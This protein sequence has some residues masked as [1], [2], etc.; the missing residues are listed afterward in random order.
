VSFQ[1]LVTAWAAEAGTTG[2]ALYDRQRTADLL[3]TFLGHDDAARVTAE[4]VVRW[5]EARLAAGRSTKT[6]ANDIGELRP[7]W[8]W[9]KLNRKL[10]FTENPFAGLAPKTRK[11]GR[12][13]RGPYTEAEAQRLLIAA[14]AEADA[15]LRWL[16]WILCFTGARL[17][18]VTQAVK[19]DVQREGVGPW[20][21]HIH[22]QGEG[23]TLK[24]VH[25]E[26]MVPL[27]SALIAEGLLRYV[28]TLPAGASLFPDLRPDKFGT[29]KGTATKK[30]GRWVRLTVGIID[31]TKDPATHGATASRIRPGVLVC[32]RT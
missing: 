12:R 24:T 30:H 18:E 22:Q 1:S 26:R 31:K 14:R 19:E 4:D 8:N 29:L 32:R 21:I 15:S 25:S 16:P 10:T 2:K 9:G 27:H 17:G 20:F 13:V 28:N 7:I 6:V 3:S 23:R 5:K 11:G